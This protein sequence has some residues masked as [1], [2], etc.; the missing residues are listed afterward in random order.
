M[1]I[2][3]IPFNIVWYFFAIVI[4]QEINTIKIGRG[5]TKLPLFSDDMIFY[6][7]NPKF[8]MRKPSE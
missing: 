2:F 7:E 1:S 3:S 5:E 6:I 4:K 8:S